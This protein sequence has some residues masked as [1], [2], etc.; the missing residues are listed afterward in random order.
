MHQFMGDE[1]CLILQE[2]FANNRTLKS[3]DLRGCNIHCDGNPSTPCT[4]YPKTRKW[5]EQLM[6]NRQR[7][8]MCKLSNFLS[9]SLSL[10]L[11]HTHTHTHVSDSF[12]APCLA[13]ALALAVL[14]EPSIAS[15]LFYASTAMLAKLPSHH[16]QNHQT[17]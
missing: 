16:L 6:S 13:G 1:G 8:A 17:L 7:R 2:G 10:S 9:L 15:T 5:M 12:R 11:T 4:R 14:A 3:L